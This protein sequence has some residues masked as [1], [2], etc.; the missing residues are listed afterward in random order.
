[1]TPLNRIP[2]NKSTATAYVT[3]HGVEL[4]VTYYLEGS[5]LPATDVDDEC[6][7]CAVIVSVECNGDCTAFFIKGW[8]GENELAE[9]VERELAMETMEVA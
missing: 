4:A 7:P 8:P 5:Y 2:A 1:M 6:R 3:V 9:L